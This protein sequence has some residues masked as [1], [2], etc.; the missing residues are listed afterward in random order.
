MPRAAPRTRIPSAG[1]PRKDEEAY[2]AAVLQTGPC[3]GLQRR[4]AQLCGERGV[5]AAA[6]SPFRGAHRESDGEGERVRPV[7]RRLSLRERIADQALDVD[8]QTGTGVEHEEDPRPARASGDRAGSPHR[9]MS[10]SSVCAQSTTTNGIRP[11]PRPCEVRP[12]RVRIHVGPVRRGD[13][14]GGVRADVALD[15]LQCDP[16]QGRIRSPSDHSQRRCVA[17]RWRSAASSA[18]VI[19]CEQAGLGVLRALRGPLTPPRGLGSAPGRG[20]RAE[21]ASASRLRRAA[22]RA[23]LAPAGSRAARRGYRR[24]RPVR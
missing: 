19:A 5:E 9:A 4:A 11:A 2:V 16:R 24:P 22:P 7:P 13:D 17:S 18:C 1:K 14:D 8:G 15:R 20:R 23:T 6:T 3:D 10:C 21:N 12:R